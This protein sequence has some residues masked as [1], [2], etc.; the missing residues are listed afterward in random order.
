MV[1]FVDHDMLVQYD[2]YVVMIAGLRASALVVVGAFHLK[3]YMSEITSQ[4]LPSFA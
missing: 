2:P 3:P 1:E 4:F